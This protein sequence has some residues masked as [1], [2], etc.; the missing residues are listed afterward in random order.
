MALSVLARLIRSGA[1]EKFE[2]G[3]EGTRSSARPPAK[4]GFTRGTLGTM[5]STNRPATRNPDAQVE[6]DRAMLN[7]P[8]MEAFL[9]GKN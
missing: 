7:S 4:R 8:I 6:E 9:A 3:L 5:G 1:F 2:S